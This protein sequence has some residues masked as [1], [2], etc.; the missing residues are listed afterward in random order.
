V[1]RILHRR[2][3]DPVAI[4]TDR[5]PQTIALDAGPFLGPLIFRT[6]AGPAGRYNNDWA[7]WSRIDIR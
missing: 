6:T 4:E 7:Y 2:T 5:G 3:L 1:R